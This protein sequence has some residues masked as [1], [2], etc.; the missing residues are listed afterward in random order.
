MYINGDLTVTGD[1][2]YQGSVKADTTPS[3]RRLKTNIVPLQNSLEKVSKIRGVYFSW[4]E[5]ESI[6]SKLN[7]GHRHV[8]VIAQEVR[9]VLPEI[10]RDIEDGQYFG[11][12]YSELIPLVLDAVR[13]LDEKVSDISSH[14]NTIAEFKNNIESLLVRVTV[15]ENS[16]LE[17]KRMGRKE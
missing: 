11:V 9:D 17:L 5:D 12:Q 6:G 8:G 7:D 14:D 4:A 3:D 10:V 16:V 13:E 1:I 2:V 15:L